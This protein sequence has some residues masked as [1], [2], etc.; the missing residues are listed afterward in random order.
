[1]KNNY[2]LYYPIT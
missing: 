2:F 1:M